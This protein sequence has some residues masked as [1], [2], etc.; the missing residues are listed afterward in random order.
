MQTYKSYFLKIQL[1]IAVYR[2]IITF[3]ERGNLSENRAFED[4]CT[5]II[6]YWKNAVRKL[7]IF[8]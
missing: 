3:P 1:K 7:W 8:I 2:I 6:M 5:I 4:Y